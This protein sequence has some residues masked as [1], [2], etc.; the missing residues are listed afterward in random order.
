M[1]IMEKKMQ[2]YLSYI[3]GFFLIAILAGCGSSSSSTAPVTIYNLP[4]SFASYSSLPDTKR[5]GAV[6]F[7]AISTNGKFSNYSV[8]TVAGIAGNAGF[9]N[10]STTNGPPAQFNH[11]L[12]VTTNGTD[13][14]VADYG[15]NLIRQITP[16]GKV[17]SLPVLGLNRPAGITTDGISLYV[18]DTGNNRIQVISLASGLATA[19]IGSPTGLAGSV[20]SSNEAGAGA[21]FNSPIGITTDGKNLYV[22]DYNNAIVRR[23]DIGTFAVST[24]AGVSGV[25][26][27]ADG[28]QSDAR[29]NKPGR[30]TT[31]GK[32]LYLTDFFNRTIRRIEISTGAVT[33]IAGTPGQV[34]SDDGKSDGIGSAAHFN[35]PN[36]IT[37]DGR[38]LYITDSYLNTIRKLELATGAVTTIS[39][40]ASTS[41][42]G[43]SLDSPGIPTFYSPVG[44]TTDGTSLFVADSFNNTIRRIK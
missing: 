22:T 8:T 42:I 38:N 11:P 4:T 29:F 28:V 26:G 5:G 39:G 34:G 24:L 20:D 18:A 25:S 40:V 43:G 32:Y 37:T 15:N 6:Q 17:K 19:I 44:I 14:Y 7:G 36:G 33:T 2:Q 27:S 23:I 12:D 35:Q 3:F 31:D 13:L 10:Y 16:D 1:C 21:L 9:S 41:G 30:I